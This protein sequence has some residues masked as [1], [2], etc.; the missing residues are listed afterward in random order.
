VLSILSLAAARHEQKG[1]SVAANK[2]VTRESPFESEALS[3]DLD[4][5]LDQNIEPKGSMPGGLAREKVTNVSDHPSPPVSVASSELAGLPDG[6][7]R[8][9]LPDGVELQKPSPRV[10]PPPPGAVARYCYHVVHW[11]DAGTDRTWCGKDI[12]EMSSE[13]QPGYE[14]RGICRTCNRKSTSTVQIHVAIIYA[15]HE[16]HPPEIRPPGKPA[17]SPNARDACDLRDA[18]ILPDQV[19]AFMDATYPGYIAWARTKGISPVMSLS[20]VKKS[21]RAWLANLNSKEN[22]HVNPNGNHK[23]IANVPPRPNVAGIKFPGM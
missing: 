8:N 11:A 19:Q 9:H 21:I 18:G 6:E 5:D 12:R 4:Q 16:G 10:P 15:W 17:I 7:L 13:P 20:H 22:M 14:P 1:D 23:T 2:K 3:I